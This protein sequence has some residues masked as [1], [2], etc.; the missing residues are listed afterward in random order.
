MSKKVLEIENLSKS[1]VKIK[2]IDN[3]N[4]YVNEGEIYGFLGPNGAG[5]TTTIKM[6]LGLLSIDEGEIKVNG[7]NI[8]KDFEKAMKCISGIVENPDMYQYMSGLDN[9]K[10]YSRLRNV[11]N[12]RVLEVVELVGLTDRI[13]DKVSKYSLGMKQRLGLALSLL[14]SP[15]VLILDEPT[16]GLDPAG[17]RQLR[18]ILKEIS[19]KD[20]VA[21]FISSHLLS[22]MQLMCDKVAVINKGKII[23]IEMLKDVLNA[24]SESAKFKYLLEVDNAEKTKKILNDNF[25]DNVENIVLNENNVSLEIEK[26]NIPSLIKRLVDEN[27]NIYAILVKEQSLEDAFLNM[28]SGGG[29]HE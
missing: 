7:F 12:E 1:F 14:H 9:L 8:K 6:I 25:N 3:I 20:K 26:K 27:I 15:K 2:I 23:K 5:K 10:L 19:H 16:N 13:N 11:N 22:E 18:D 4:L 24:N 29:K 17:I 21:V 28:T